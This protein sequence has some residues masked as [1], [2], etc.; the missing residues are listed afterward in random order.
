MYIIYAKDNHFPVENILGRLHLTVYICRN[1]L[2]CR[3]ATRTVQEFCRAR[4]IYWNF[5]ENKSNI[6]ESG[7]LYDDIIT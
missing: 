6:R 7:K 5:I 1:T 3:N 4:S 2:E